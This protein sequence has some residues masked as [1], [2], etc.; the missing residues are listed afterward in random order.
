MKCQNISRFIQSFIFL[1]VVAVAVVA[2]VAVAAVVAIAGVVLLFG[3]ELLVVFL[4][5]MSM[6]L[7]KVFRRFRGHSTISQNPASDLS[8]EKNLGK[9][10][11]ILHVRKRKNL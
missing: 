4:E 11:F 7:E 9:L 1:V 10:T 5:E 8:P 3:S 2:V 6:S